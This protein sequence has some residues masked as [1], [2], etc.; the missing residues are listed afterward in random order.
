MNLAFFDGVFS[1]MRDWIGV[2]L[3][4]VWGPVI[5]MI[6]Y[7][8]VV[9]NIGA[10]FGAFGGLL[11]RKLIARVHSR[12]G[13]VYTGP[14]GVLQT[15]ADL[16]KFVKKQVIFPEGSD[17]L[18]FRLSPILMVLPAYLSFVFLPLGSFLLLRSEYS[19][20]IV[21]A[22]LSITPIAI[23]IGSW[24]SNSKYATLGGLRAAGMM[25]SYEVLMVIAAASI[26]LHAGTL[27][28]VSIVEHQAASG[29]WFAI[30]Q[31]LA[32]VLFL[33]G[34]VAAVER[35][36]FDLVEA[37]SELVA[38]WKT[39]YGGIYFALT[40]L[41]EYMKLLASGILFAC[42]FLGGWMGY[43]GDA[44]FI[45]KV[46][47]FAILMFY[48]RATAMRLR[49]DQVLAKVWQQLIPLGLLNFII[50][51]AALQWWGGA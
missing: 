25:M 6:S 34:I 44:G 26:A 49:I 51:M 29:I 43:L 32:F 20:L 27:D 37:E 42:L 40:L 31:P 35:N 33:I 50:T 11:E 46:G 36:P 23:L 41:S 21:L 47:L 1:G 19:L 38:G 9:F 24:S 48:I 18:L 45:V 17:G 22:L 7:A 15:V 39:E 28:I 3:G 2:L 13:P 4:E 16:L 14:R 8:L 12:V 30:A 10:L 5:F